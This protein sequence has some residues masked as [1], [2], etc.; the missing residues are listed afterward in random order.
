[1]YRCQKCG[2]EAS[3]VQFKCGQLPD[4]SI[5]GKTKNGDIGCGGKTRRVCD[6]C[7]KLCEVQWSDHVRKLVFCSE[8]CDRRSRELLQP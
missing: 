7:G 4:G 8:R 2:R 6:G 3:P 5:G 1:M